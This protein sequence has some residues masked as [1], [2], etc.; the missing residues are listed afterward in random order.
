VRKEEENG[1][2]RIQRYYR[3]NQGACRDARARPGMSRH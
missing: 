2:I 3:G 1:F